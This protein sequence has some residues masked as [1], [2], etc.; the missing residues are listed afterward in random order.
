MLLKLLAQN[1]QKQL[2]DLMVNVMKHLAAKEPKT[3]K[4]E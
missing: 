4:I 3:G 1:G 2:R